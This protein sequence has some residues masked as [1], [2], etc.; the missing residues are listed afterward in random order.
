MSPA[1]IRGA[2][3]ANRRRGATH[4][5]KVACEAALGLRANLDVFGTDY[6]T[7]DGTCVRDYIHVT[8]LAAPMSTRCDYLR[9]G[10]DSLVPIAAM[11]A[12][13]RCSK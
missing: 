5:I 7:P 4:L 1:P 3:P 9:D 10:G 6:P 2:A 11:G 12:A 13:F 8:D